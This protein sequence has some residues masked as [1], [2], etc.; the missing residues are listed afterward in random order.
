MEKFSYIATTKEGRDIKGIIEA[1]DERMAVQRIQEMGYFPFRVDKKVEE[2]SVGIASKLLSPVKPGVGGK[3]LM[4]FTYQ[5]GV[6]LD[7]GFPL[8][9]S[10]SIQSEL[11]EKKALKDVVDEILKHVRNG[12]SFSDSLSKFPS[13]FPSF[14]VNMV[15]AGEAGGFLEDT[16]SKMTAYLESTQTM[17]E[18][19]QSALIYPVILTVVGGGTVIILLTFVVPMFS[20]IFADMEAA[21]PLPTKILL[22]VSEWFRFY[23]WALISLAAGSLFLARHFLKSES[24]KRWWDS[25]R[26]RIPVI[27]K[28]F[29]EIVVSRFARTLGTLMASGVPILNSLQ[30]VKGALGSEK[31]SLIISSVR[32]SVRKGKGISEPL[33]SSG[34]FPPLAVHMVTIGEDTGR[35]DEMLVK[36]AERFDI[37]VRLTTKRLLTL[38]GPILILVMGVLVTFILI[39]ILLAMLTMNELPF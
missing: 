10:L 25:F 14:Y 13:V 20:Q 35:L 12:K 9:K 16:V 34:I 15:R 23:W 33:R 26:F 22:V 4:N 32:E 17:K 11:T 3:D 27:G 37:E 8:E 36:I 18:D 39:S 24:G 29:R 28:L 5:L 1:S 6:L 30:I 19:V 31:M 38:F 2:N 21:L 7:A